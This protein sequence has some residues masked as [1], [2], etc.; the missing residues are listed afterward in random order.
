MEQLASRLETSSVVTECFLEGVNTDVKK[1]VF[2]V[3]QLP[4]IFAKYASK[5]QPRYDKGNTEG[6][7]QVN[8]YLDEVLTINV[9]SNIFEFWQEKKREFSAIFTL[10]THTLCVPASSAPG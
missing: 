4:N 7:T 3:R 9:P 2:W 1:T 10:S 8:T 6:T 5:R